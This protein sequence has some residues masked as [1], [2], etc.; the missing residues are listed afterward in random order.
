MANSIDYR[1]LK[2]RKGD[3][4]DMA[5]RQV[6]SKQRIDYI[7]IFRAFGIIL[8]IMG[9]IGFGSLFDRWIH[10]FHMPMFFVI[11]GFFYRQQSFGNLIRSRAKSLLIPYFVFGIFHLLLYFIAKGGAS[12]HALYLFLWENTAEGGLPIAG[13]LWFLTAMFF[14]EIIFWWVQNIKITEIGKYVISALIAIIGMAC[15]VYL[16]F[17]L[18]WA[19]DVGMLGAGMHQIGKLIREKCQKILELRLGTAILGI[20]AF[21]I[22]GMLNGYVNLRQGTYGIWSLFW[23]TA[24]GLIV[25]FWNFFRVIYSRGERILPHV[26]IWL[27]RIG[28]DLIVYL[29]LNQLAIMIAKKLTELVIQPDGMLEMLFVKLIIFTMTLIELTIAHK[30]IMSTKLRALVGKEL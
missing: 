11:S 18:P 7:D 16:S 21:S 20:V 25:M 26:M 4:G 6:I 24:V 19:F 3:R 22:I 30:I 29:C 14:S 13:A 9:H 28:R 27:R 15:A 10:I 17:R 23:I 2:I 5:D 1:Y 12:C 8:M